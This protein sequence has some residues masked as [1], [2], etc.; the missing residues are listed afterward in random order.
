MLS[1]SKYRI[2]VAAVAV[3]AIMSMGDW[4]A[5]P[6]S[7]AAL[8]CALWAPRDSAASAHALV[9]SAAAEESTLPISSGDAPCLPLWNGEH[10]IS[11]AL[12]LIPAMAAASCVS[13]RAAC[14]SAVWSR[15]S[16]FLFSFRDLNKLIKDFPLNHDFWGW[17][18]KSICVRET[19][20]LDKIDRRLFFLINLGTLNEDVED[21]YLCVVLIYSSNL[22]SA[23]TFEVFVGLFIRITR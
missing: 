2:H 12:L 18:L 14:S 6:E 22:S 21:D 20:N 1:G 3:T 16:S 17:G 5:I 8:T 11:P 9:T 7:T 23:C 4:I 19:G 10:T 13:E 15:F